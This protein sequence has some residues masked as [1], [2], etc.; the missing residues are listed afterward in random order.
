MLKLAADGLETDVQHAL[1]LLLEDGTPWDETSVEELVRHEPL[2][3]APCLSVPEVDLLT[4]DALLRTREVARD[5][6]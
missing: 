1:E 5:V 2:A 3:A 4:Y 6:A